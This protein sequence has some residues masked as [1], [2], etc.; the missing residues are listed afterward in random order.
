MKTIVKTILACFILLVVGNTNATAQ[1]LYTNPDTIQNYLKGRI[2]DVKDSLRETRAKLKAEEKTLRTLNRDLEKSRTQ[3]Q[4]DKVKLKEAK[5]NGK[6]YQV[7]PYI[8]EELQGDVEAK[9]KAAKEAKAA[10]EREIKQKAAEKKAAEKAA[11]AEKKQQAKEAKAQEKEQLN[12]TI[13]LIVLKLM[14]NMYITSFSQ[15]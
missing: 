5:R 3:A 15:N 7:K 4:R 13:V 10:K 6:F 1:A 2:K 12:P 11:I 9:I 14:E 8:P